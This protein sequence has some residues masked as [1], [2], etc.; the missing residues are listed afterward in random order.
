M[1]D[2]SLPRRDYCGTCRQALAARIRAQVDRLTPDRLRDLLDATV[3]ALYW[4]GPDTEWDAGTP[5]GI[6]DVL[7]EYDLSVSAWDGP[8]CDHDQRD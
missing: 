6:A 8:G 7:A 5:S 4:D 2:A 1:T 3:Q